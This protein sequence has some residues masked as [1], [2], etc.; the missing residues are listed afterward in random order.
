VSSSAQRESPQRQGEKFERTFSELVERLI[1]DDLEWDLIEIIRQPTG[2][3]GG[4]D[5]Q[6][7]WRNAEGTTRFWHFECKSKSN[8]VLQ[9]KEFTDK[10]LQEVLAPHD[11]DA[12][13]LALSDAEPSKGSD[14]LINSVVDELSLGFSICAL[15]P[16]RMGIRFLYSCHRDLH[17]RQYGTEPYAMSAKERKRR[18]EGFG[19]W[20]EEVSQ[21]RPS[22]AP[23][24]WRA[25]TRR[26]AGE[27]A[28]DEVQAEAYLRGLG[29]RHPWGAAIHGWA[30]P[31][32]T[33][34]ARLLR[35]IAAR[36]PGFAY[37]WLVGGGGEGKTTVLVRLAHRTLETLDDTLV[38]WSDETRDATL[39]IEW[40][41]R[42]PSGSRVLFCV[43]GIRSF[44]GLS[45]GVGLSRALEERGICVRVVLTERGNR[46]R[47]QRARLLSGRDRKDPVLLE[48][49]SRHERE[50]L[51]NRLEERGLL[52][53]TTRTEADAHL[54]DASRRAQRELE[55]GNPAKAWL[56][57]TI[58]ELTDPEGRTFDRI[59]L[60][61]LEDLYDS[62]EDKALRL[63]L[64]IALLEA[65]GPCLP[66]DLAARL[67]SSEEDLLRAFDILDAELEKQLHLPTSF[68]TQADRLRTRGSVISEGLVHV[69]KGDDGLRPWLQGLCAALPTLVAPEFDPSLAL[70]Q[71]RFDL[72]DRTVHYLDREIADPEDAAALLASWVK[73][74]VHGFATWNRLGTACTHWVQR[75]LSKTTPDEAELRRVV[76]EAREAF[77]RAIQVAEHTLGTPPVPAPYVDYDLGDER[78]ITYRSWSV[79]EATAGGNWKKLLG[80]HDDLIRSIYLSIIGASTRDRGR[81][82][83]SGMLARAL[84]S[85]G[86]IELAV[87]FASFLRSAEGT[88]G[89]TLRRLSPSLRA[90]ASDVPGGG[91]EM[92]ARGLLDVVKG[93]L[94]G[95]WHLLTVKASEEEH[96]SFLREA[97]QRFAREVRVKTLDA[98]INAVFNGS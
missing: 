3:Q 37:D 44:S 18:I 21:R 80:G 76:E 55:K 63:L 75:G 82:A 93:V 95:N 58:M 61:I 1:R 27:V 28:D 85:L 40:V 49:L 51:A 90:G 91:D 45:A 84:D 26:W 38:F 41:Q 97:L 71:H 83:T 46:W 59:L 22:G 7:K 6:V 10:L 48:P 86:E 54:Q 68:F 72:L 50:A 62:Q 57:P 11:I 43:D 17:L 34:E 87:P 67:L 24:G 25:L 52:G 98:E 64:A 35:G 2:A 96:R 29:G 92:L 15:S 56:L 65:A 20:L 30:V 66:H 47:S 77:R 14:D 33:T 8:G 31:R 89:S 73:F 60:S 69:A 12:W 94:V 79:L 70:P 39:P 74:D 53:E 88:K 9:E 16:Q 32:E 4:R 19:A 81:V 13:C 78:R 5:L 42:L 36:E 23:G